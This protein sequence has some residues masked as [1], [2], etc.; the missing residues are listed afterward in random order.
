MKRK[1]IYIY[2]KNERSPPGAKERGYF[3][4]EN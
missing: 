2:K 4:V 1:K 3:L